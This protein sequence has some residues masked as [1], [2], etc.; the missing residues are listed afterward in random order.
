MVTYQS[1]GL[2][3]LNARSSFPY[4]YH[5][6][7]FCAAAEYLVPFPPGKGHSHVVLRRNP[8]RHLRLQKRCEKCAEIHLAFK[9]VSKKKDKGHALNARELVKKT[10]WFRKS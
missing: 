5:L 2:T 3:L 6:A 7:E 8:L 1:L 9:G 10:K 4:F